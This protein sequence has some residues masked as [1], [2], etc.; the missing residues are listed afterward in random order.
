[1]YLGGTPENR[2]VA[3]LTG[4]ISNLFIKS[5]KPQVMNLIKAKENINVPL[6]CP[7]AQKPQQILATPPRQKGPKGKHR[8]P[9]AGSSRSRSTRQ[10]CQGE[11]SAQEP[12]AVH[13]SGSS[14]SYQ[15]YDTLPAAFSK[16]PHIS[17]AIRVNSSEGLVFHV[18][19]QK[20]GAGMSLALSGGHLVLLVDGGKKKANIRSR[21]ACNDGLWHT[22]F[23]KWEGEK[24]SLILDGINAQFKRVSG[25][26]KSRLRAPLH[27]GGAPSSLGAALQDQSS[28]FVGCVRDLT[29]NEQ[30]AGS[31][32]HSQGVGPCFLSS[33]EPGAYYPGQGGHLAID[34]SLVLSRDLEVQLEVRP[35]S[36]S[37]LLLHAGGRTEQHLSLFLHQGE[38]TASLN[39]G[40]GL[41]STSFTPEETLCDGRWHTITV[42]KKKN[43]LQLH[44]D[45]AS[46][47]SVGPKQGRSSVGTETVYLGGVPDGVVVPS[48]P[49][50]LPSYHGCVRRAVLN[51]RPA[52]LSKPLSVHGAVATQGCPAI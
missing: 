44:V 33:L 22:V 8:K 1:M 30:A 39:A 40:N 11:L 47:H 32:Q 12:G 17:M 35:A 24:A 20:G 37:G 4:C 25:G 9:Q 2:G 38:V 45:A 43:V 21:K 26:Q 42:V 48:L 46:E 52:M 16:M 15:R 14:H 6:R 28:G 41:F 31:P 13:F 5:D 18:S 50:S 51:H 23:V 49:A 10:S 19:G 36:V 27:V 29:L 7:A 3:N 34:E